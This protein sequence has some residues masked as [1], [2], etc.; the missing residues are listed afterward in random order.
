MMMFNRQIN[1]YALS[2]LSG[3]KSSA[4]DAIHQRHHGFSFVKTDNAIADTSDINDD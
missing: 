2:F 1:L 4:L 3:Y